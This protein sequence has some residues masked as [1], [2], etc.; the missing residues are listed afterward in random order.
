VLKA[1]AA[2]LAAALE[3]TRLR[4]EAG[5]AESLAE[6]NALRGALLQ[7]VSHDL[8][9]PLA[10]IKASVSSLRQGDFEWSD[11]EEKEFLET[12]NDETDRLTVLVSNL[13]DMSRIQV[14]ALKP[15]LEAIA[16]EEVVPAALASLGP[17]GAIVD[18][19]VPETL[20]PV[21][22]D[23]AL[24]ERVVANLVGN[25]VRFSPPGER[26]RVQAGEVGGHIDLRVI[27]RGP[28]IPRDQRE[29]VFQPFQRLGDNQ[30]GTGVG[31]GLAVARGFVSAMGASIE[32]D[33]TPAGGTTAVVRLRGVS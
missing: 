3:R 17:R 29:Q 28:G 6:A 8:R 13:L 2:Q 26:V 31:L 1:F 20:A 5:R 23:A 10:S 9:T 18:V 24:L 15:T 27:D 33:D 4:A 21:L 14:G 7:A 25:A 32:F 12:I 16:L 30:A 11:T 19:D 22:A